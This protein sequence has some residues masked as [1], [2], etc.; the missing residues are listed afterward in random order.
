MRVVL[1]G[2]RGLLGTE[3]TEV[4][5]R[6]HLVIGLSRDACD[7]TS[8]TV[9][10]TLSALHPDLVIHAAAYTDVDGCER[11][12]ERAFR[13]NGEGTGRVAAACR[14]LR[15][16]LLYFSTD[17]IFDGAKGAP[18]HEDDPPNPLSVYGRSKWEGEVQV[19]RHLE[20][21]FI[22]RTAWLYGRSGRSF[23]R[24]ILEQ[25]RGGKTL[26]VVDDQIGSP[27]SGA[28]LAEG[29]LE[30]IEKAPFGVYHLTNSGHCTRFAFAQAILVEAGL[31]GVTLLPISSR[32]LHRPAPRPAYSVLGHRA[33]L[34]AVGKPLRPWRDALRAF[35]QEGRGEAFRIGGKG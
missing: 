6:R 3:L 1:T 25:A 20:E 18:Y 10:E 30:L 13:I 5:G 11:D 14:Q 33:W 34:R 29:V 24:T 27:T 32:E 35:F 15:V 23:V 19:R 12:P 17:Y 21:Y 4:V 8:P 31:S 9:P 2:A 7:V 26:R 28:D 16:P 22:V